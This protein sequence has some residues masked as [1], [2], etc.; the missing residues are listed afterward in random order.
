MGQ[1]R[2]QLAGQVGGGCGGATHTAILPAVDTHLACVGIKVEGAED[3][4]T[5]LDDLLT[6]GRLETG[7]GTSSLVRWRDPSG[8]MAIASVGSSGD[9]ECVLP[10]FAGEGRL[11]AVGIRLASDGLSPFRDRLIVRSTDEGGEPGFELAVTIEDL[12]NSRPLIPLDRPIHLALTLFA[13]AITHFESAASFDDWQADHG[14]RHDVPAVLPSGLLSGEDVSEALVTVT[15][16]QAE[17]RLNEGTGH[18][19]H[20]LLVDIP[21]GTADLVAEDGAFSSSPHPGSVVH[22]SVW[23]SGRVTGGLLPGPSPRAERFF[24]LRRPPGRRR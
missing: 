7:P 13:E 19:F 8:A 12:A 16:A 4:G 1:G 11:P 10:A 17:R 2:P 23:V 15:V 22:G 20:R 5:T 9:P 3:F 21:G 6:R 18:H 14:V 24:G